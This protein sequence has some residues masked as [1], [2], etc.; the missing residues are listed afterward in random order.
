MLRFTE[1][2]NKHLLKSKKQLFG[3]QLIGQKTIK[4]FKMF[5]NNVLKQN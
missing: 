1:F 4:E 5:Q 3:I 2:Y